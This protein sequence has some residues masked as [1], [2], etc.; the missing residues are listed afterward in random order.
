MNSRARASPRL[1]AYAVVAGVGL[2]A[3]LALRRP[4]LAV[5]AAPFALLLAIGLRPREEPRVEVSFSLEDD[6][7]LEGQELA[8]T[9]SVRAETPVDRLELLLDLPD[10]VEVA[11][12]ADAV[13]LRLRKG[14]ERTIPFA[15]RCSRWGL[16]DVGEL[17]VRVRDPFR[18]RVWER[19]IEQRSRIKAYPTSEELERVLQPRETQVFTGSEVARAK[20]DGIEYADIREY[21]PGDR[22]RS[23]NWRASARRG[24]LV[25]SERH[26]ERNTDVV[27]FLDSF[28]D[29]RREGRSTLDDAVRAAST[30]ASRYLER[31]DR[32][33]LVTFGGVLRW[34]RPGMGVGQR[35]RLV[36]TLLETGV[37]PTYTWRDV[38]IIPARIL[39][40]KALV[41]AITPLVDPRFVTTIAD[42]RARRYDVAVVE[43][44][45][46]PL[47]EPG[48]SEL[49][50]L[51]HRLWL[52]EREVFRA[53]IA[54][55]GVGVGRWTDEIELEAA[56]EGVRTFR[57]RARLARV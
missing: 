6:R 56:L 52:L 9:I 16:Y 35:F 10:G 26:P 19:R 2:V 15:L 41:I 50:R 25:V 40:T 1:Q 54:R 51:A 33:G 17:E 36:E 4:E 42:L 45:P 44:D 29:V 21:V 20:G 47:V 8:A 13:A 14:E 53:R 46:V 18:I 57:R 5:A 37:E 3:S 32:V 43:V 22:L 28:A 31:R 34:L 49:E 38:N 27:L 39:P 30:L 7:V 55:L 48:P 12:G 23:I 24:N 11:D